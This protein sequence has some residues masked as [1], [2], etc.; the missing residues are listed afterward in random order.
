V[1]DHERAHIDRRDHRWKLLGFLLLGI[2]W[3]N[4]IMWVS[5]SLLCRDIALACDEKVIRALDRENRADYTQ[6]YV[7][8]SEP[9]YLLIEA[10]SP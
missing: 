9:F 3:F 8:C 1:A 7:S 10:E 2:H 4:P 6:A 5:Y